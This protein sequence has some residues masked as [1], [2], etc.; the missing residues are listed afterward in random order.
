MPKILKLLYRAHF[1]SCNPFETTNLHPGELGSV[2]T[3]D[4]LNSERDKL[5]LELIELLEELVALL[6]LKLAGADLEG[7]RRHAVEF[8]GGTGER[9]GMRKLFFEGEVKVDEFESGEHK[10]PIESAGVPCRVIQ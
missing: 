3:G 6:V 1:S 5:G 10:G 8:R 4:L 2:S 9:K 7:R